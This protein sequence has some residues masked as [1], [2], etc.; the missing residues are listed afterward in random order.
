MPAVKS[1]VFLDTSHL[2]ALAS[3]RD[4]YHAKSVELAEATAAAGRRV[5]TTEAVLLE[6]GNSLA[7]R[8]YRQGAVALLCSLVTD[9]TAT[10]EPITTALFHRGL[11]LYETRMDKE[12]G[13][14]DCISFVVMWDRG[15]TDVLTSDEHFDQA[16]FAAL[17]RRYLNHTFHSARA[18]LARAESFLAS[19]H[20]ESLPT[21]RIRPILNRE[22]SQ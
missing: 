19:E 22:A 9:P 10:I 5:V 17:L 20:S 18:D 2:I 13:L 1:D 3:T 7:K 16:G 14:V 8:R 15:L 4:A 12:W 21:G 11:E 6:V